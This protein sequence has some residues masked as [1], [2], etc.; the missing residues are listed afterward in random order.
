MQGAIIVQESI[1]YGTG[2]FLGVQKLA[3]A[4]RI[5]TGRA[6]SMK[7]IA[8]RKELRIKSLS[9]HLPP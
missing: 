7:N 4:E 1:S 8:C 2:A 3:S 5:E 6:S 9:D